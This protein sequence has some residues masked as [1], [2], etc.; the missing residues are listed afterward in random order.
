MNRKPV[1]LP[2]TWRPFGARLVG[3]VLGVMLVAMVVML[4]TW[5]SAIRGWQRKLGG[6]LKARRTGG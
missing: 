6:W 1:T 5:P 3:T 4:L 2:H